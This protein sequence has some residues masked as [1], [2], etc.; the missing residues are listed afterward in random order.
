VDVKGI[1]RARGEQAV[2]SAEREL[3]E[4]QRRVREAIATALGGKDENMTC[5]IFRAARIELLDGRHA[6]VAEA[7]LTLA[8]RTFTAQGTAKRQPGDP[9]D[10]DIAASLAVGR[11]LEELGRQLQRHGHAQVALASAA[12]ARQ[13]SRSARRAG[14][15]PGAG[16]CRS[17]RSGRSTAPRLPSG[18]TRAAPAR[19]ARRTGR[20]RFTPGKKG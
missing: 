12:Q 16:C 6:A 9:H 5:V 1:R 17:G 19:Q 15:T 18:P 11:A 2:R 8:D 7:A 13:I 4:L 3:R 10:P 20:A 14:E